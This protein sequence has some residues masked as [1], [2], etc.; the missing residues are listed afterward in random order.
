MGR[1]PM[2]ATELSRRGTS[3]GPHAHV[4]AG[5][6]APLPGVWCR[7]LVRVRAPA[8]RR[9]SVGV[10]P[11][12]H[13]PVEVVERKGRG[14]PD[15]LCDHLAEWVS[16][17]LAE[18]YMTRTGSVQDHNVDKGPLVAGA[19][20]VGFGGGRH[21]RPALLTIAGRA[22][23]QRWGS[24][25]RSSSRACGRSSP[26]SCPTPASTRSLWTC[27]SALRQSDSPR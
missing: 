21:L 2:P 10:R 5:T 24:S 23:L 26:G 15:T 14:D 1:H 27:A 9:L 6:V 13:P 17:W 3:R 11:P 20:E 16:R 22:E 8:I 19:V 7:T 18:S 4:R 12:Y 25:A